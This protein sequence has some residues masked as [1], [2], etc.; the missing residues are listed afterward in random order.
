MT[1]PLHSARTAAPDARLRKLVTA[2]LNFML[3]YSVFVYGSFV[4]ALL[5][6]GQNPFHIS[7]SS[8]AWQH[9]G[10]RWMIMFG[11]LTL[12]FILYQTLF[13]AHVSGGKPGILVKSAAFGCAVLAIGMFIPD[14]GLG[15]MSLLHDV[16]ENTGST[17]VMLAITGMV[18]QC[19]VTCTQISLAKR[20]GLGIVYGIF[21]VL[22]CATIITQ[23]PIAMFEV[24]LSLGSMLVLCLIDSWTVRDQQQNKGSHRQELC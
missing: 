1:L 2:Q 20:I 22:V 15:T 4:A 11:T 13:F 3:G 9:D 24:G 7:L 6:S 12:P 14:P 19:C 8:I 23:G 18:I 5:A 17:V 16:F 21:L 10:L